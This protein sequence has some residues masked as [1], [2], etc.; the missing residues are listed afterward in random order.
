MRYKIKVNI[1]IEECKYARVSN[2]EIQEDGRFET[3]ISE[4][5]AIN[6]DKCEKALLETSYPTIRE[7]ISR[8]LT[9]MSEKKALEKGNEEDLETNSHVY[10]V[11]GEVG[12]FVFRG[13]YFFLRRKDVREG[14]PVQ[15]VERVLERS[16]AIPLRQYRSWRFR[17]QRTGRMHQEAEYRSGDNEIDKKSSRISTGRQPGGSHAFSMDAGKENPF[18]GNRQLTF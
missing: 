12:R 11:D 3:T 13:E 17:A 2:P 15:P 4:E 1:E 14:R 7:A 9:N 6:I 8:H 5:D 10:Q 16:D 18:G